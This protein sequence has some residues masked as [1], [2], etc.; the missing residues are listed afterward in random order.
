MIGHMTCENQSYQTWHDLQ[1]VMMLF[2]FEHKHRFN[3]YF[4]SVNHY[5]LLL[6]GGEKA[7]LTSHF[8]HRRKK[9]NNMWSE[10]HEGELM[11]DKMLIFMCT[12]PL[13]LQK[14]Q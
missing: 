7:T 2:L 6:F 10:Q 12:V 5:L 14:R 11:D 13:N 1:Y 8:F 3:S 4:G 9:E